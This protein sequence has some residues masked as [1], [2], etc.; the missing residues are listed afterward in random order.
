LIYLADFADNADLYFMSLDGG[1]YFSHRWQGFSRMI[2]DSFDIGELINYP[3][4]NSLNF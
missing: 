3:V 1:F 4:K 2:G